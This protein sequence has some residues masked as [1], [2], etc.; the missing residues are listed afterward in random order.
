[1]NTQTSCQ[2]NL[3]Q[4]QIIVLR[5]D[6]YRLKNHKTDIINNTDL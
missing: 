3:G 1:M 4:T 5:G 6:S 2:P